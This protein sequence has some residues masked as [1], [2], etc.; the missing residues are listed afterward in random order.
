MAV[1]GEEGKG[2]RRRWV[3]RRE[4]VCTGWDLLPPEIEGG[5]GGRVK[6]REG[7]VCGVR[8]GGEGG[9]KEKEGK[10]ASH[11]PPSLPSSTTVPCNL[12]ADKGSEGGGR[13]THTNPAITSEKKIIKFASIENLYRSISSLIH[14]G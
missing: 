14:F 9:G 12:R 3:R 10:K 8:E 2:W 6:S 7:I 5:G 4:G 1:R 11:A 13:I